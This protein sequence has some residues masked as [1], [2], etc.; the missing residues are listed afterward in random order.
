MPRT[1]RLPGGRGPGA[2]ISD[3]LVPAVREAYAAGRTATE[4]AAELGVTSHT[5]VSC[6]KG[7]TYRELGG[8]ISNG[9]GAHAARGTRLPTAKLDE[10]RV[11]EIRAAAACGETVRSIA[12]RPGVCIRT[13]CKIVNGL[14]WSHVEESASGYAS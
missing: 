12:A 1:G 7:Q 10:P 3:A 2:K 8:P 6:V 11:F 13:L 4:L 9:K 5:V 14:T